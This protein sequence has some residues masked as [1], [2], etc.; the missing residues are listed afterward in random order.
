M[1]TLAT[2]EA[3]SGQVYKAPS[4]N[5]VA[6]FLGAKYYAFFIV[7][8]FLGNRFQNSV[9]LNS[10]GAG[11]VLSSTFYYF[12]YIG[13]G[14]L[15]LGIALVFPFFFVFKIR[16]KPVLLA[17]LVILLL[18]EYGLY[19][20]SASSLDPWNG[21]YNGLV[22]VIFLVIFFRPAFNSAPQ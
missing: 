20:W 7:L 12:V 18:A 14:V 2:Q 13:W 15:L 17:G 6:A 4:L 22:T 5:R 9:L 3:P 10:H 1:S 8:A 19:T 16:S 21:F 11:E